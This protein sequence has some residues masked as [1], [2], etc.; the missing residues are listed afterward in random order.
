MA[1]RHA[2]AII[3]DCYLT[4]FRDKICDVAATARRR[5]DAGKRLL[6]F[7][8]TGEPQSDGDSQ[9]LREACFDF[10]SEGN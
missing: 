8:P 6:Y 3:T 2:N 10:S 4:Y 1:C 9:I 7:S 5:W